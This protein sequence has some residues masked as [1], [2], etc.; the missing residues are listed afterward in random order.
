M[1]KRVL[2]ILNTVVHATC[3]LSCPTIIEDRT[4][5]LT[6]YGT[7]GT[8]CTT[9]STNARESLSTLRTFRVCVDIIFCVLFFLKVAIRP[10][11][12]SLWK[13]NNNRIQFYVPMV[14]ADLPVYD[15]LVQSLKG[16]LARSVVQ[17]QTTRP[18]GDSPH[19]T[20][21]LLSLINL[22]R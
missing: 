20:N 18:Y 3:A 14:K 16:G 10:N 6:E 15:T 9:L 22:G 12:A 11:S 1:R 2:L 21:R 5:L 17:C 19:V 8:L 7:I 4:H 13:H